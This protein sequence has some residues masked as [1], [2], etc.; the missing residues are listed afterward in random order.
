MSIGLVYS[1]IMRVKPK[2]HPMC[3][4]ADASPCFEKGIGSSDEVRKFLESE[5]VGVRILEQKNWK[6]EP[7]GL[8]EIIKPEY[9]ISTQKM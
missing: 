1:Q 4:I 2:V 3:M 6:E 7:S 8:N 5:N 9:T